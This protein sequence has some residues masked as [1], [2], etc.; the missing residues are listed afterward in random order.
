MVESAHRQHTEG[1]QMCE[2][3]CRVS[4]STMPS[5]LYFSNLSYYS[6]IARI[7]LI[8]S[9]LDPEIVIVSLPNTEHLKPPY[10]RINPK[11][12]VPALRLEDGAMLTDS[13]DILNK[14]CS[15]TSEPASERGDTIRTIINKLY[16][17][18]MGTVAF[19]ATARNNK[20]FYYINQF[21]GMNGRREIQKHLDKDPD[22]REAYVKALEI[23]NQPP[24]L[25]TNEQFRKAVTT[26]QPVLVCIPV[27]TCACAC[28]HA[29]MAVYARADGRYI[30]GFYDG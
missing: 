24:A 2:L 16:S 10:A 29:C 1:L 25:A 14:V 9:P 11:L 4:K 13:R 12:T 20:L 19:R 27:S 23:R 7:A 18:P 17:V 8:D 21:L 30:D 3:F 15:E 22:L 28:M 5:T 6:Q 26:V